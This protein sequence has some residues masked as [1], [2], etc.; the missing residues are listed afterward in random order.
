MCRLGYAE[1]MKTR[2]WL[3]LCSIAIV[4]VL[5]SIGSRLVNESVASSREP[6]PATPLPGLAYEP[7]A[8]NHVN[9]LFGGFADL[10]PLLKEARIGEDEWTLQVG[11]AVAQIETAHE[12]LISVQPPPTMIDLHAQL[13]TATAKCHAA[14]ELLTV[15]IDTDDVALIGESGTL[16]QECSDEL[17]PLVAALKAS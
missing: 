2:L 7:I 14:T 1:A 16:M 17:R 6:S 12:I 15:G 10:A 3:T 4:I 9:N 5:S 8:L 13:T 11:M